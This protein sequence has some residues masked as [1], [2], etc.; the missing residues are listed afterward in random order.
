VTK[1][2]GTTFELVPGADPI[3]GTLTTKTVSAAT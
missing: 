1:L 3:C 2:S